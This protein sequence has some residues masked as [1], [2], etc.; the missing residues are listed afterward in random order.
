ML[1]PVD[2]I[3]QQEIKLG[4]VGEPGS[5]FDLSAQEFAKRANAKLGATARVSVYGSSQLGGDSE[6]MKKLKLGTVDL[7]LPSTVMSSQVAVFGTYS[8]TKNNG[9]PASSGAPESVQGQTI[10]LVSH[11]S[12]AVSDSV[13]ADFTARTGITVQLAKGGEEPNR[14]RHSVS[15]RFAGGPT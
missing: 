1:L 7:A 12:F 2:A 3:A 4:H 9:S 10:T 6:L 14:D 5:L 13:L 8:D 11:D 15:V